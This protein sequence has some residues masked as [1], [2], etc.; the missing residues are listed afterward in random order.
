M[1]EELKEKE[2]QNDEMKKKHKDFNEYRKQT[3][4]QIIRNKC[5]N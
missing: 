3:K 2:K 4:S 1:M 5:R